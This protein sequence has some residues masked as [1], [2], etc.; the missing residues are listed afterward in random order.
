MDILTIITETTKPKQGNKPK[1]NEAHVIHALL[2]IQNEQPIGRPTL[3]KRLNLGDATVRTLL[4]RLKEVGAIKVDKVGGAEITEECKKALQEWNSI[5]KIGEAELKSVNWN[6]SMIMV[7]DGS[8]IIEKQKVIELRD[9]IIKLGADSV[10]ISIFLNNKVELP[11]KTEEFGMKE[12]LEEIK[13]SCKT[14]ENNDLIAFILPKDLYLAYKV[15]LFLFESWI[16]S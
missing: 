5:I 9:K 4:R 1:Y 15:G 14:C 16:N 2:I 12:L 11:P 13:N 3:E 6:C 10:L 8:K 7:K